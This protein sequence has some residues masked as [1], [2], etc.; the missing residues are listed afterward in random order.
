MKKNNKKGFTLA[1]LLIVVAIIAVLAAISIPVFS[2]Q[3]KRANAAVDAA[4][5]RAL[6]AE[7]MADYISTGETGA[8]TSTK[9]V[10]TKGESSD[11]TDLEKIGGQTISWEKNTTYK[12]QINAGGQTW[13][14]VK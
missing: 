12:V 9:T 13:E 11:L 3:T 7:C 4:N 14:L 5:I 6:Y 2:A 1:E 8:Y 10:T